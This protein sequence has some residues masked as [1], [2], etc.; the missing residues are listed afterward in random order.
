MHM[1]MLEEHINIEKI[2]RYST[3]NKIID[4]SKFVYIY[5]YE[6]CTGNYDLIW[7]KG[8]RRAFSEIL[9]QTYM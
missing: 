7:Y 3:S 5:T 2:L 9:P 6:E 4:L 8:R 1:Q